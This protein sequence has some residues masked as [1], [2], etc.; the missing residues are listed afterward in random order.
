MVKLDAAEREASGLPLA[1]RSSVPAQLD[2]SVVD[3]DD[4]TDLYAEAGLGRLDITALNERARAKLQ[5]SE[6]PHLAAEA[7]R[8][9][10]QQKMREVTQAQRRP[11]DDVL[12]AL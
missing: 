4:I 11:P 5:N 6:T 10:I 7:L 9:L 3:A 1:P 8:R 12:R 2:A